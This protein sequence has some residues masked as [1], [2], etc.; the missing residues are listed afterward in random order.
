MRIAI[1]ALINLDKFGPIYHVIDLRASPLCLRINIRTCVFIV[2]PL[3]GCY[4][5]R[6]DHD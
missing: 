2:P 1:E 3:P 5:P 4:N 6:Q